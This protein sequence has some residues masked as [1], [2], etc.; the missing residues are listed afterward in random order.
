MQNCK[1]S[2]FME[3][4]AVPAQRASSHNG[5]SDL[6]SI[7]THGKYWKQ[8]TEI[9]S[10]QSWNTSANSGFT[11]FTLQTPGHKHATL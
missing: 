2:I 3:V 4:H 6:F 1:H 5:R 9:S 7:I 10:Y 8:E 11:G